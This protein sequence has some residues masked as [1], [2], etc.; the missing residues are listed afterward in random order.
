MIFYIKNLCQHTTKECNSGKKTHTYSQCGEGTVISSQFSG[1]ILGWAILTAAHLINRIPS[2]VLKSCS[3]Y[4]I[5]HCEKPEYEHLWV[6]D[7]L[8]YTQYRSRDK[9]KFG[10]RSRRCV[11]VGY[12]F[13]QKD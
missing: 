1:K 2:S 8:C 7:S 4:E 9:E 5:L 3:P 13:G 11:F 10:E 6:F 12:P